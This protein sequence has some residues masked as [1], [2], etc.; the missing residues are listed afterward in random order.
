MAIRP[1][2]ENQA[3]RLTREGLDEGGPILGSHGNV[4]TVRLTIRGRGVMKG[5]NGEASTDR[6][7]LGVVSGGLYRRGRGGGLLGDGRGWWRNVSRQG[8]GE[9]GCG[10]H[11]EGAR[12][13]PSQK[14]HGIHV[15]YRRTQARMVPS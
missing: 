9:R 14:L 5:S 12:Q 10:P 4:G 7:A 8:L 2:L 15:G 6:P 11:K 13:E 1:Q 3:V